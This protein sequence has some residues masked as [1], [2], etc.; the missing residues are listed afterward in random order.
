MWLSL[1]ATAARRCCSSP[2]IWA[3]AC[4]KAPWTMP[5]ASSTCLAGSVGRIDN[6]C[7][8]SVESSSALHNDRK[9]YIQEQMRLQPIVLI[10]LQVIDG[11]Q[12]PER[13][14]SYLFRHWKGVSAES[15]MGS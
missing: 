10:S 6:T 12:L 3:A 7:K 2:A 9:A 5:C 8:L 15:D 11:I 14:L 13:S 4:L 1:S